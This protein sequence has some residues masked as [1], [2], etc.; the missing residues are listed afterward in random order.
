M[1]TE[2]L[3]RDDAK[4]FANRYIEDNGNHPDAHEKVLNKKKISLANYYSLASKIYF[5]DQMGTE[6]NHLFDKHQPECTNPEECAYT[7]FLKRLMF[8]VT[9]EIDLLT[10]K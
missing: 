1:N 6:I 7:P 4:K 3:I 5:L 2:Q 10:T 9:Q 8:Y